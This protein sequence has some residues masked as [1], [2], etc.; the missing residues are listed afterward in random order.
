[1]IKYPTLMSAIKGVIDGEI[2]PYEFCF[3]GPALLTIERESEPVLSDLQYD[4]L[5]GEFIDRCYEFED[6]FDSARN[7]EKRNKLKKDFIEFLK[8]IYVD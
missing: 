5:E 6:E 8:T 2:D 4:T 1:M 3:D 7:E